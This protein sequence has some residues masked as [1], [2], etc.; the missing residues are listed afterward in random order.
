MNLLPA[1]F[2]L[3]LGCAAIAFPVMAAEDASE[4]GEQGDSSLGR[5]AAALIAAAASASENPA[6]D[7]IIVTGSKAKAARLGGSA[8]FLDQEDLDRFAFTDINRVLRQ[9]P[10]VQLREEEGFGLRPNIAIRGSFDD[11]S[12]KV[13][14]Y[15][16]GVLQAPAAYSAPAAYYFPSIARMSGVEVVKGAGA[17]KYGPNTVA[18]AVHMVSTPIPEAENGISGKAL[19]QYGSRNTLRGHLVVGGWMDAGGSQFG[20][21]VETFQARADGFKVLDNGGPTGFNSQDYVVKLGWRTKDGAAIPQAAELRYSRYNQASDETYLGITR[22]DFAVTPRRRYAGSQVDRIDVTQEF[23]QLSHRADFG[24]VQLSTTAYTTDTARVW[25]KLQDVFNAE[26]QARSLRDVL[27]FPDQPVNAS[28]VGFLRG[29]DSTPGALRVR[30]NDRVYYSKGIQSVLSSNFATGAASHALE[31]SVRYHEDGED[32]FQQDDRFTMRNGTMLLETPG[33]PGSQT[34]ETREAQAWSFFL[35]DTITIGNLD[36]TPGLR[37]ETINLQ[38]TRF[39][40]DATSVDRDTR[41]TLRDEADNNLQV[42]IP[43]ISLNW[44]ATD[45]L[46]FIGGVHRGFSNPAAPAAGSELPDAE[47]STNWEAG[48]RYIDNGLDVSLVGFFNN[49]SNFVGTCTISSGGNCQIGDQFSGGQVHAKGIEFSTQYDAGRWLGGDWQMPLGV[50]YTLTDATFR[51]DLASFGPW[52]ANVVAGDR[53]PNVPRHALT[54]TAGI[55][56][57]RWSIN[58]LANYQSEVFNRGG[59]A[60]IADPFNRVEARWVVDLSAEAEVAQGIALF[61]TAENVFNNT[62]NVGVLP[63]GLRPGMPRTILGG[64]RLAF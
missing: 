57:E 11:R 3:M 42:W 22:D 10:G 48:L 4:T 50:I 17:I 29:E 8:T 56:Q 6:L 24:A 30:A 21:M 36:V 13:A 19:L 5:S 31:F 23:W 33:L 49:Y 34:N 60:Q 45:A 26:G 64:V 51:N 15:E 32:R 54:L 16:D 59:A 40:R 43:G 52:A 1:R 41:G 27:Q 63:S 37:F 12:N 7:A 20:A 62:F 2:G 9:V 61:A 38:R 46:S 58:A 28:A 39:L 53:V 55:G 25:Y 35:R 44:Q 14:I 47:R 18:G